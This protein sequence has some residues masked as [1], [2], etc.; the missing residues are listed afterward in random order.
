[1][2]SHAFWNSPD[3]HVCDLGTTKKNVRSKKD[4]VLML[5]MIMYHVYPDLEQRWK[6]KKKKYLIEKQN[7][8]K[9][10]IQ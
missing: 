5:I 4:L 8:V 6:K 3:F 2:A 7:H 9:S 10:K 1:V